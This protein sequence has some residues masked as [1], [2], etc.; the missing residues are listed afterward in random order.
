MDLTVGGQLIRA[1]EGVLAQ[2]DSA[3][4]DG[5]VFEAPDRLDLHREAHRNFAFGHGIHLCTGR[6]LALIE[7]EVVFK[8]LFQRIPTL[9][10][11]V[12]LEEVR[13]KK[14]ENLLGVHELPLTW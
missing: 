7:F 1:G 14:D 5:T 12:P 8:T 11:A 10:L 13:F 9:R 6:A 4:R 2:P 3:N